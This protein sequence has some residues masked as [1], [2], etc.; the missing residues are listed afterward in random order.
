MSALNAPT[1]HLHGSIDVG[2]EP[3]PRTLK[4]VLANNHTPPVARRNPGFQ[5]LTHEHLP[6]EFLNESVYT[7]PPEL[8][9]DEQLYQQLEPFLFNAD[10]SPLMAKDLSDLPRTLL[11]TCQYDILRDEGFLYGKRL[12]EHGVNVTWNHYEMG[13]HAI[14]NFRDL[15]FELANTMLRDMVSYVHANV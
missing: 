2:V 15:Q 8:Y 3:T 7:V 12:R 1:M 11:V 4:Q 9:G 14:L 6:K 13:F 5:W 10:F